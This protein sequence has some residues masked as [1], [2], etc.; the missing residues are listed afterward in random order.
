MHAKSLETDCRFE[1]KIRL[2][3][4]GAKNDAKMHA[5]SMQNSLRRVFALKQQKSSWDGHGDG[6][7]G[8]SSWSWAILRGTWAILPGP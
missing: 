6:H 3:A 8:W 1:A 5:N 4:M 7:A 2:I